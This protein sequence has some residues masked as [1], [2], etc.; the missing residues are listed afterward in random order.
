MGKGSAVDHTPERGVGEG[1][2]DA[3]EWSEL[4]GV[5]TGDVGLPAAT[6]VKDVVGGAEGSGGAHVSG[7]VISVAGGR[8]CGVT[9]DKLVV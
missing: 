3:F 7:F 1:E 6:E 4:K 8:V 9:T 2:A 5:D